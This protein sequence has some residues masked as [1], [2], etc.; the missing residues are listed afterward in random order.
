MNDRIFIDTN[1][2]IYLYSKDRKSQSVKKF[3][4]SNFDNIILSTQVLNEF[5]NVIAI[6]NKLK[7]KEDAKVIIQDLIDNFI[8]SVV[9]NK[10]IIIA[11]D[12]SIKYQYSY[13]DSLISA[14]ALEEGCTQLVTED[15]QDGQLINNTLTLVNPTGR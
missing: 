11:I 1:I 7:S 2:W 5:Y 4:E 3:I 8:I 6:K 12:I 10:T 9:T 15:M 13:F 14:S